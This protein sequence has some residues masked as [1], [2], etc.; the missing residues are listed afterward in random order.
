MVLSRTRAALATPEL[1]PEE[2]SAEVVWHDLECGSYDADLDLWRE[3][4]AQNPGPLLEIGAGTGRVALALA[5]SGHAVTALEREPQLL[6][7]LRARAT[8]ARVQTVCADARSF[9][10]PGHMFALCIVP[11]QTIQLLGGAAGRAA[12]LR[13]AR[14]H[15]HGGG[16]LACAILARVTPFNCSAGE[17]GPAPEHA[18]IAGLRYTSWPRRVSVGTRSVVI[19]R[20]R[21]IEALTG[22]E[23]ARLPPG[24]GARGVGSERSVQELD[25]VS[26]AQL[27]REGRALGFAA[28]PARHIAATEEHVGS[29]VVMLRA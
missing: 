15:L 4:A 28:P 21:Q 20:E 17:A 5:R 13:R 12:F 7:A 14:A 16:L 27:R 24:A 1:A 6:A 29:T 19:E 18:T 11:M 2:A 23:V 10:L 22:G 25:R 9:A 26:A 8:G 3:L